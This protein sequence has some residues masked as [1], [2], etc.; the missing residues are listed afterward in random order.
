M[1][2]A[3]YI[4][5]YSAIVEAEL[6]GAQPEALSGLVQQLEA[7]LG[8]S[9]QRLAKEPGKSDAC[10]GLSAPAAGSCGHEDAARARVH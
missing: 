5:A 10:A 1:A 4:A 7:A 8:P 2:R 9:F 3:R 6:A